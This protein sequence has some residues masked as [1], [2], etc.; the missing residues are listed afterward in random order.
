M[1]GFISGFGLAEV[2]IVLVADTSEWVQVI[3]L[4]LLLHCYVFAHWEGKGRDM[5]SKNG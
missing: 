2:V 4:F 3:L 5:G 1:T